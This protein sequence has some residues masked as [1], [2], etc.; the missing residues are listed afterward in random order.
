V[1]GHFPASG[2]PRA[3][4]ALL[5]GCAQQVLAPAIN[6]AT[7]DVLNRNGVSVTLPAKPSCCGALAWHSGDLAGAR[8]LARRCLA[9]FAGAFDAVVTNA[10]GCGSAMREYGL[11]MAGEPEE[12]AAKALAASVTDVAAILDQIGLAAAVPPLDTPLAVAYHDAC[13]LSHGQGVMAAPRRLLSAVPGLELREVTDSHL[14]CGS[15]GTY[16]LEQ[17]E[18]AG[19]LGRNKAA[20]VA[21]TSAP[22]VATGNI[23]CLVQLRHHLASHPDPPQVLHTIEVLELAYRGA[24]GAGAAKSR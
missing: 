11:I 6:R 4:V 14:C 5:A 18:I 7:I 16:N 8:A 17:P 10:A 24:L 9:S 2:R 13:H 20:A 22:L 23:G 1:A 3:H 19:S 21:A 15:A 12:A